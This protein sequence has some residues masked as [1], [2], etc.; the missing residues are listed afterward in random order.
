MSTSGGNE[1][2]IE[3]LQRDCQNICA[4]F[5]SRGLD[6]DDEELLAKLIAEAW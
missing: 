2:A 6:I 3:L 1:R 5:R 4:W